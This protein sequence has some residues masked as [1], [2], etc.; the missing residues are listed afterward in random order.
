MKNTEIFLK[1]I[2]T[3]AQSIIRALKD[4]E[5]TFTDT[6]FFFDDLPVVQEAVRAIPSLGV[7]LANFK[8]EEVEGLLDSVM[9]IIENDLSDI[10][11]YKVQSILRGV[12]VIIAAS[13]GK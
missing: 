10:E 11:L 12:L 7:E 8:V 6:A 9:A 13:T 5:L 4:G 2:A 3:V 1:G